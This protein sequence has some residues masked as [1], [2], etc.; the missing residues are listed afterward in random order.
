MEAGGVVKAIALNRY[1]G[2]EVLE[3]VELPAPKVGP[4]FLLIRTVAAGVNPVDWKIREG[5][6]DGRFDSHFPLV[7]GW[8]VAGVVEQ[9]GPAVTEFA[10]GDEVIGYVRRDHIQHGAYAELV[11]APERTLAAKPA[12]IGWAEAAGLPLAGLT[13]YQAL[14]ALRI[15]HGDT[16]LVHA[17]AGGVGHIAVQVARAFGAA[18]VIGTASEA[19]HDFLRE[20]GAEPVGYGEGLAARIRALAP[21][22]V[23]AVLDLVGG[24]TLMVSVDLVAAPE[25]LVSVVDAVTVKRFG[26]GY[27]FVRPAAADLAA[28][29]G[30][31]E[32]GRLRV[33]VSRTFPLAQAADAQ[34]LVQA[35]HVRGK[36]VLW[37]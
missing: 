16:V 10:A 9:V 28:L 25:R 7:P 6:L 24:D 1:G 17:A 32:A 36:V 20:L 18:R 26:G 3:Q 33:H 30:F 11:S 14:R 19:N 5:Y 22:G 31:V 27:V 2:P 12:A 35:G 8:D 4:D 15:G 23:D 37:V 21:S 29:V 13:A 34:R